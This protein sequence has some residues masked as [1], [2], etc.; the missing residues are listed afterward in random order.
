MFIALKKSVN[1][2]LLLIIAVLSCGS[3][4]IYYTY[5]YAYK[6]EVR[7]FINH[8]ADKNCTSV[9]SINPSEL[10]VNTKNIT[11]EDENKEIIYKGVLYDIVNIKNGKGK[12]F[13]TAISDI[14][15][16]EIKKQFSDNFEEMAS[17]QTKNPLKLLKQFF[18][19]KYI[20]SNETLELKQYLLISDYQIAETLK[21]K[22]IFLT[23]EIIPPNKFV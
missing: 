9:I 4:F 8:N 21:L 15:E 13:I 10:Y 11:W 7:K 6:A 2:F 16:Q 1:I 14:Q 20:S 5:L 23:V 19:L 12:V 3:F 18:A 17:N 22:P